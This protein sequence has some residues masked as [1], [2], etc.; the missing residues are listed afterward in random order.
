MAKLAIGN[1]VKVPV[2]LTLNNGGKIA[3]FSFSVLANRLDQAQIKANLDDSES[4]ISEFLAEI[5]H[6]WSGQTLV[7]DDDDKP[8]DFSAEALDLMLGVA[9]VSVVIFQSYLKEVGA[10]AKN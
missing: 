9:G 5:I 3:S 4:L 6:D 7:L 1:T 10:K 2:K 8:S